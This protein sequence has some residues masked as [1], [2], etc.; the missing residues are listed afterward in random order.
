ML[1][2]VPPLEAA[3]AFI[4]AARTG[5]MRAAAECLALSPSALSRRVQALEDF[6][7]V[8]L[9][10]RRSR[11]LALTPD[12]EVFLEQIEH[13]LDALA[14]A[15]QAL[16][17]RGDTLKIAASHTLTSEWLLPRLPRLLAD[18]GIPVEIVV[19]QPLSALKEGRADLA[20]SGGFVPPE[21]FDTQTLASCRAALLAAPELSRGDRW[22]RLKLARPL[23]PVM[24]AG[25]GPGSVP[26]ESGRIDLECLAQAPT[27]LLAT[28]QMAY[29]TAA[30]GLGTA[31]GIPLSSE[32]FLMDG[33]VRACDAANCDIQANYFMVTR[34]DAHPRSD[35]RRRRVSSWLAE[36]AVQS[37]FR[38]NELTLAT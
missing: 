30:N 3:E 15:A 9:F 36:E 38:F 25:A 4:A 29:E 8:K 21:G 10:V 27:I 19:D 5:N 12:G 7:G 20:L 31:L 13:A 24:H 37:V 32:R 6:V 23:L 26:L 17:E 16:R 1:R 35:V 22:T 33:R 28:L 11:G 34:P 14:D 2:S 18:V